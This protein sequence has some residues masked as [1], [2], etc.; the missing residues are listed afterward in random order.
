VAVG[1]QL[2]GES[3]VVVVH[4]RAGEAPDRLQLMWLQ[5]PD[6]VSIAS[7]DGV[8][9]G[10][11]FELALMCDL[12]VA[13]EDTVLAMTATRTGEIPFLAPV[14]ADLVGTARALEL[15]LTGRRIDAREAHEIGLLALAVPST[16]L[17]DALDDLVAVIL[18]APREA[19]IETKSLL[20]RSRTMTDR[21]R[22]SAAA[23][24]RDRIVGK[25]A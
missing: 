15:C 2:T 20:R 8:V 9:E 22:W 21:D 17:A 18:E 7:L 24:A 14:L 16:E 23:E 4:I 19:V 6:L 13:T 25:G 11:A 3:R 1:R 12:R 5:R 10:P